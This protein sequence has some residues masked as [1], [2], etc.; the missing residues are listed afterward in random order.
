MIIEIILSVFYISAL[1]A[2]TGLVFY[3]FRCIFATKQYFK[4][5]DAIYRYNHDLLVEYDSGDPD[6]I[7]YDEM[8][9]L[10]KTIIRFWDWGCTRIL[11]KE[12]YELVKRYI[13]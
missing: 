11:P 1:I 13:K 8:E 9:D 2:I 3:M 4:I 5:I 7:E 10:D 12:R 6:L